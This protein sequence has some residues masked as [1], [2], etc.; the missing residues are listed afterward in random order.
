MRLII[1]N[2]NYSTW[3]MRPW[4]L[5]TAFETPFE[6]TVENLAPPQTL[7]ARLLKY[8]PSARVPVLQD[9]EVCIW[10]SLAICEYVNERCL[11][12][13]GYPAAAP[14]RAEARAL[15]CEMHAGFAALRA[16]LPMNIRAKRRV[17]LSEAVR[18]DI[19]RIDDIWRETPARYGPSPSNNGGEGDGENGGGF[20]FGAF[21]IADCFYAPVAMRFATYTDAE[22]GTEGGIKLSP[23][24]QA[25]A[26]RLR[27]HAAVAAWTRGALAETQIVPKD[28][29]GEEVK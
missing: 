22:G 3:S 27:A 5:L 20:L 18:A 14:A 24:A 21:S 6:E 29:T 19:R 1:G 28:E 13:R 8:S 9:G 4:L 25:Y 7:T 17:N 12:G 2:K 15:V 10:D 26:E 23:L 16:A 11:N